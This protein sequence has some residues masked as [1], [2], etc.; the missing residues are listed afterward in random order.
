MIRRGLRV[1]TIIKDREAICDHGLRLM[2]LTEVHLGVP[3]RVDREEGDRCE[4]LGSRESKALLLT[5]RVTT[6]K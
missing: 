6:R 1:V 2:D 4:S 5:H 3:A